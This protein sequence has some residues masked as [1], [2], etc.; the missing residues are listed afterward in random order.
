MC[1]CD[2]A[3]QV[4][5]E[6]NEA[7]ASPQFI[8]KPALALPLPLAFTPFAPLP[9]ALR[10]GVRLLACACHLSVVLFFFFVCATTGRMLNI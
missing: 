8:L 7:T 1:V 6:A 4:V 2:S 9:P 10:V 3:M 5:V